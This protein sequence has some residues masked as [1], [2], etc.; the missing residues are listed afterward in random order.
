MRLDFSL[1]RLQGRQQQRREDGN[2]GDDDQ[3]LNQGESAAATPTGHVTLRRAQ[4]EPLRRP[5]GL[6]FFHTLASIVRLASA[7]ID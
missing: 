1:A 6:A 4:G 7:L 2:D 5:P 3:Q